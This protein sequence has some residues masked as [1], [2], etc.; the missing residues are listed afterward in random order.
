M[1]AWLAMNGHAYDTFDYNVPIGP[2]AQ[3]G[4]AHPPEVQQMSAFTSRRKIDAVGRQGAAV[5]LFEVKERA[6]F[7]AVGQLLGYSHHW[8]Q[9]H[10][11]EVPP[12][13]VLLTARPSPGIAEVC[14]R[15]G[16]KFVVVPADFSSIT[17]AV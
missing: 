12:T 16:I 8:E 14:A 15:Y 2:A 11:G 5:T 3:I 9:E 6:Q 17:G 13:L 10:A 4:D 7:G 1:A